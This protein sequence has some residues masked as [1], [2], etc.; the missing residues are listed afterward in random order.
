MPRRVTPPSAWNE[1][2]VNGLGDSLAEFDAKLDCSDS[3]FVGIHELLSGS[4]SFCPH[5]LGSVSGR[6]QHAKR[7]G[8]E[9]GSRLTATER[10]ALAFQIHKFNLSIVPAP[11]LCVERHFLIISSLDR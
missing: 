1:R 9:T 11:P 4:P 5:P 3:I 7:V 10:S 8:T 6:R 2:V